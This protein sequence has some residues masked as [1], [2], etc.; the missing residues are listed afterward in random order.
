VH[1][2]LQCCCAGGQPGPADAVSRDLAHKEKHLATQRPCFITITLH[3]VSL[4][5]VYT[6]LQVFSQDR[7][8]LSAASSGTLSKAV[9]GCLLPQLL[10]LTRREE[11]LRLQL[12]S[13]GGAE[14]FL[15]FLLS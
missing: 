8:M 1:H 6:A 3:R 5:F 4:T 14:G 11:I 12:W 7:L 2:T 15:F 9:A 10:R 13:A